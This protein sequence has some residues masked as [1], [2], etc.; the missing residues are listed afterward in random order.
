MWPST[1]MTGV[2]VSVFLSAPRR[3]GPEEA[4][5]A[6]AAAEVLRKSRRFMWH[7]LGR[8]TK[9]WQ[10]RYDGGN[11]RA[12]LRSLIDIPHDDFALVAAARGAQAVGG[13]RHAPQA[14]DA[15]VIRP[16]FLPR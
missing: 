14:A 9:W 8:G 10:C 13:E 7:L 16:Q 1:P 11:W 4:S 6:V 5:T 12:E 2:V 3:I 15:P